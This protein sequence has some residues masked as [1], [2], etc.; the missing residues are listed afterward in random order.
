MNKEEFEKEMNI[1]LGPKIKTHVSQIDYD[2]VEY[3][4]ANLILFNNDNIV[5][6]FYEEFGQDGINKLYRQLKDIEKGVIEK[7]SQI[8]YLSK[9]ET[10]LKRKVKELELYKEKVVKCQY[11]LNDGEKEEKETR[12][13]VREAIKQLVDAY[14]KMGED[15][16]TTFNKL[17]SNYLREDKDND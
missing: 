15:I 2:H 8:M 6:Q 10:E 14:V 4:Y 5:Y 16:N 9:K 17:D 7:D 3:V 13:E 11:I 12:K 1:R